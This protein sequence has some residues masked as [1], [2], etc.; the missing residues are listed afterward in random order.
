[1]NIERTPV[2]GCL[3]LRPELKT[4]ERG[5]FCRVFCVDELRKVGVDARVCQAS[6]AYNRRHGTLRG[7]HY[8]HSPHE[9]AKVVRCTR[10]AIFDVAVDLRPASP[11]Y[12]KWHAV[13][14]TAENRVSFYLPKGIAH[15]L[16]TLTDDT[17]VSY[18]ISD[19]YVPA[20]A[21]GVRWDDP[22]VGVKWPFSPVVISERDMTWPLLRE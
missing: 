21:N 8:Q 22:A 18:L 5:L 1:M 3:V 12:R 6:T 7:M 14:L 4:D 20:A 17:E 10:G 19:P 9:E 2:D 16:L 15:G 11:T 13:E